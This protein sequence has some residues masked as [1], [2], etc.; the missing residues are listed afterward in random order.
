M[1]L[2]SGSG[3]TLSAALPSQEELL[4]QAAMGASDAFGLL[5]E[6]HL[7]LFYHGIHRILGNTADAQD[8][9]QNALLGVFQDLPAFQ[10][11]S[12]FSSWAYRICIR[13]MFWSKRATG[14]SGS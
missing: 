8:A 4:A 9:L 3:S 13:V 5:V 10:G 6:P 2:P 14:R 11:R 7:G 12:A 1:P